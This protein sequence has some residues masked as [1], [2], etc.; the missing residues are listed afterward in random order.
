MPALCVQVTEAKVYVSTPGCADKLQARKAPGLGR[1]KET[2]P[3]KGDTKV[4]MRATRG[5]AGKVAAGEG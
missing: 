3:L 5:G 1:A 2:S 4:F